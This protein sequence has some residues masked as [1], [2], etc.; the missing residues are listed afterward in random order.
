MDVEELIGRIVL[1]HSLTEA[2]EKAKIVVESVFE[3]LKIKQDLFNQMGEICKQCATPADRVLLCSNTM[4][5]S[6]GSITE[7]MCKEYRGSCIGMRFLHPVWFIDEVA[8]CPAARVMTE[9]SQTTHPAL[10][11]GRLSSLI[12]ITHGG[13]HPPLQRRY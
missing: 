4:S 12:A 2:L 6:L 7:D 1:V 10:V 5:L 3:D 11:C 9:A 8:F 13:Q